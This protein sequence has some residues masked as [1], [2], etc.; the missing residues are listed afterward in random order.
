[1]SRT[2][3]QHL[4]HGARRAASDQL[5][6]DQQSAV[7]RF[8]PLVFPSSRRKTDR[9][10]VARVRR[11]VPVTAAV[12]RRALTSPLNGVRVASRTRLL[13]KT[14]R[15]SSPIRPAAT[16]GPCV[17]HRAGYQ[18]GRSA[19]WHCDL[20][21]DSVIDDCATPARSE[22]ASY[23]STIRRRQLVSPTTRWTVPTV[24]MVYCVDELFSQHN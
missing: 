17:R 10:D 4:R 6:T 24:A 19:V 16:T 21:N 9:P 13:S 7:D 20:V 22:A 18:A 23:Q 14:R 2:T 1:L 11:R 12:R 15:R 5:G 8:A 3:L